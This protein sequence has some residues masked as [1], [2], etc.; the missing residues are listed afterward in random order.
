MRSCRFDR[1]LVIG[2]LLLFAGV[3]PA[4]T[5]VVYPRADSVNDSRYTYDYELLRLALEKT[6]AEFGPYELRQSAAPM[7]QARAAEEIV[8]GSGSVNIFVR[9][10]SIEHETAMLPI[11]IP[12]E[13]GLFSYRVFL[14]RADAQPRFAAVRTLDDLRKY[15]VGSFTTWADTNILRHGGFKVVTGD[16]YEGLFRMLIAGRFDFF[17]RSVDE[18]YREYDER[19][20][21]LPELKVEETLLLYFPST[22]YFFVQRSAAG[23]RLAQRVEQ[24]LNGMIADGSFD[25]HFQKYKGPMIKR[26]HLEKRKLFRIPNP[27]LSVQT[28]LNRRELWYQAFPSEQ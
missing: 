7:N 13:K 15:S 26:A 8:S 4:K 19:K 27:H 24:G 11:R 17:S 23:E 6:R 20:Q 21:L 10:T 2:G 18:A 25:A 22:R 1:L 28:P 14:I 9:S 5:V 16:N 12:V 3:V